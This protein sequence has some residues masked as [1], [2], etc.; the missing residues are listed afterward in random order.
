MCTILFSV[1][2][3]PLFVAV[4]GIVPHSLIELPVQQ[5]PYIL[6]LD[7]SPFL[8]ATR[9]CLSELGIA[10]AASEFAPNHFI[11]YTHIALHDLHDLGADILIH[12][13]GDGDAMLAVTAKFDG[14]VNGLEQGLLVDT[15]NDEVALVDG[16]GTLGRSTD[17]DG[18]EGVA[19][20][21]E[22]RGFLWK[23]SAIADDGEGVHLEAVVI[24]K[25]EGLMLDDT[26]VKLEA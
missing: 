26:W 6:E 15:S 20:A 13:V 4:G 1:L 3:L 12:I 19:D 16:L 22:E 9:Q 14:G 5:L 8:F 17:A 10:L 7:T 18:G 21:S 2:L 25:A 23:G 24:V 11:D